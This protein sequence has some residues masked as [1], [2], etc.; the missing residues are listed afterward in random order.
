MFTPAIRAILYPS[1]APQGGMPHLV[2]RKSR[3]RKADE[4]T[5]APPETGE[6]G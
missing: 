6:T 5:N 3:K 4:R 2:A 1:S